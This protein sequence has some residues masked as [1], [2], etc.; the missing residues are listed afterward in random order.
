MVIEYLVAQYDA[1][2]SLLQVFDTNAG[3]LPP[4]VYAEFCVADLK[5]I[6]SEIKRQRPKALITVFAKDT[7]LAPF[8]NSAYNVVGV[9]WKQCPTWA[10]QQ[11]PSKILQGN[12]DPVFLYGSADEIEKRAQQMLRAFDAGD[13]S[14]NAKRH[15]CNLGH[16]MLPDHKPE[17]LGAYIR[18]V[19]SSEG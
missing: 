2:A 14:R 6:A 9:S 10:R 19:K 3:E 15:I 7:E 18:A 5:R 17:G 4:S 11:C 12:L 1:G 8:D 16:G 13:S